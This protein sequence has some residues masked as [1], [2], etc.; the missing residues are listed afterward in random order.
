VLTI[1]IECALVLAVLGSSIFVYSMVGNTLISQGID[2][3]VFSAR[4]SAGKLASEYRSHPNRAPVEDLAYLAVSGSEYV[5]LATNEGRFIAASG[6]KPPISP[7]LG[8]THVS[9]SGWIRYQGIPYLF[10]SAPISVGNARWRVIF[11][12]GES[13]I[14]SLLY[15]LRIA[16]A[17]GS[18]VLVMSTLTAVTLIVRRVT[19]PLRDLEKV[20][21]TVT[22]NVDKAAFSATVHSRLSEVKSLTESF[23]NMLERL[24]LAQLRE[25]EFISNAAHSLRTPIQ[26]IQGNLESLAQRL[27]GHP[28]LTRQDLKAVT[29]ESQAM[30]T[31][32]DRLLQL[33]SAESDSSPRMEQLDIVGYLERIAGNLRDLCM[34]HPL[35]LQTQDLE[36]SNVMTDPVLLEA[37]LRVLVENADAYS[38]PKST[39]VVFAVAFKDPY[40]VRVGI[41]NQGTPIPP[42]D[43]EEIF[44]RFY[45]GKRAASSDHYGL[46]LA[47]ADSIVKRIGAKWNIRSDQD[48]TVF[49]IDLPYG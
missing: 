4:V 37:A 30:A 19:G 36:Q 8:W 39:V 49:A 28:D 13:H 5:L 6:V 35:V 42:D 22:L 11:V 45:R 18:L 26:V 23:N 1:G 38:S 27:I 41:Q 12:E 14:A 32:V 9:R 33:S 25:R 31:L 46:G 21:R 44:Q 20:A 3:V 10:A 48:S 29:R 24:S 16:L 2:E 17:L 40:I 34:H 7:A 15:T 47:I 43:L